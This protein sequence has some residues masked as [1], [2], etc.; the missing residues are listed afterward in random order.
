MKAEK[1]RELTREELER[2]VRDLNEE[3]FNLRFRVSTQK[4]DNPLRIRHVRRDLARLLTVLREDDLGRI[5]L[6]G[7]AG[8]EFGE[9]T[10][11][12]TQKEAVENEGDKRE[13]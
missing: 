13:D 12:Q 2:I 3:L 5:R 9:T 1:Y 4:L 8:A 6:P 11:P 7:S 10:Q